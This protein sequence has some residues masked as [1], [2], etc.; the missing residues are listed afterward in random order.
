MTNQA[1]RLTEF[2]PGAGCA[3]KLGPGELAAVLTQL[4]PQSHPDLLVGTDTGD[5]AA[6][7]RITPTRALVASIDFF[8][9]L[10]DDARTWGWIAAVNAASDIWAMGGRPLFALGIV[11]WPRTELSGDI[12]VEV[13]EGGAAAA[14]AGG[15]VV[16]GGHSVDDPVPKYG[17]AV[18]GEV[19]PARILTNA[20]LRPGDSLV[21][22]KAIGTGIACTALKRGLGTGAGLEAGVASMMLTNA[23]ASAAALQAGATGATD[24]TGFGLLG[25]LAKM[26][27]ASGVDAAIEAGSVP[28]LPEVAA[29][30]AQGCVPGGTLRNLQWVRDSLDVHEPVDEVTL[31]LLADAQTS[32]GLLFG[33]EP[34][35]AKAA[36]AALCDD[37][38]EA[39]II[40][41]V[42]G[43]GTGRI[44]I[45]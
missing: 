27:Q 41:Q 30:A 39:A 26:C 28:L 6:V 4:T 22:T 2:S 33:A 15:W 3:C 1:K 11:A 10:V 42:S 9:P 40:G 7:W 38:H 16:V 5:D 44:A 36:V 32:G 19:D 37:D 23:A 35:A 20:G 17:Q 29:L 31:T 34:V 13:L 18:I 24:V 12:L 25:H 14:A 43:I 21:L 8:T 45:L